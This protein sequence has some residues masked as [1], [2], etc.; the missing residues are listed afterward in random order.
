MNSQTDFANKVAPRAEAMKT[1]KPLEPKE[2]RQGRL[3]RPVLY[4]LLAALAIALALW[5][6]LEWWGSTEAPSDPSPAG[7]SQSAPADS[8]TTVPS[9]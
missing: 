8:G 3:G 5:V 9:N 2:A 4:V 6:P 7:V 1:E